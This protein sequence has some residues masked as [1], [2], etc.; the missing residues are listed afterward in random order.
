METKSSLTFSFCGD[1]EVNAMSLV[2]VIGALMDMSRAVA[3]REFPDTTFTLKVKAITTGSLKFDFVAVAQAAQTLFAPDT[4]SYA[5]NLIDILCASFSIKKALKGKKPRRVDQKDDKII[6][7]NSEGLRIEA[8]VGAGIYFIDNRIDRAASN[9]IEAAQESGG[10]TGLTVQ[11]E[12]VVEI[13]RDE[14]EV[15]S[16]PIDLDFVDTCITALRQKETL[17]VRQPDFTGDAK[18]KFTGDQNISAYVLDE[19]FMDQVRSGAV[20]M[21]SKTYIVADIQVRT[22]RKPDGLPDTTKTTYEILKVH[23]VH[24]VGED[25]MVLT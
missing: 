8:P 10:A 12:Q 9:A 24:T 21:T 2:K 19:N 23:E 18:W 14:F 11:A 1:Y 20:A 7:E 16:K 6:I 13:G 17:F 15:C 22:P 5:S 4:L 25:Q 3:E